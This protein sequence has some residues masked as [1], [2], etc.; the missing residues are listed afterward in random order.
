[1]EGAW[2]GAENHSCPSFKHFPLTP[3]FMH[4]VDA[5]ALVFREGTQVPF[6]LYTIVLGPMAKLAAVTS[7]TKTTGSGIYSINKPEFGRLLGNFS[8]PNVLT[9]PW[10]SFV[11]TGTG[12]TSRFEQHAVACTKG[13]TGTKNLANYVQK[14]INLHSRYSS[15]WKAATIVCASGSK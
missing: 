9:F 10:T 11:T 5:K 6:L 7:K 8:N 13:E 12:Y 2:E 14:L 15:W 3:S 1:M 4:W